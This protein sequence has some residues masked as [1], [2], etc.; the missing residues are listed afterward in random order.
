MPRPKPALATGGT[1]DP[2]TTV[3]MVAELPSARTDR[4]VRWGAGLFWTAAAVL[5]LGGVILGILLAGNMS[6]SNARGDIVA[7]ICVAAFGA[8]GACAVKAIKR[9]LPRV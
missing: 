5:L 1:V 4:E 2:A 6:M 3:Q 9:L 7:G 8:A